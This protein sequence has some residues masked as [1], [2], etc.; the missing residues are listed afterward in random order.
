MRALPTKT[1]QGRS[2]LRE[3]KN[4]SRTSCVPARPRGKTVTCDHSCG[5]VVFCGQIGIVDREIRH[6][7]AC[8]CRE[9]LSGQLPGQLYFH[10]YCA[11]FSVKGSPPLFDWGRAHQIRFQAYPRKSRNPRCRKASRVFCFVRVQGIPGA[12]AHRGPSR[13]IAVLHQSFQ[14]L[15]LSFDRR[16]ANIPGNDNRPAPS[17]VFQVFQETPRCTPRPAFRPNV[18]RPPRSFALR[19]ATFSSSSTSSCSASTPRRS[20]MSSFPRKA[21]SHR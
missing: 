11:A 10:E 18:P 19:P 8:K 5:L 13:L 1:P 16:R 17:R 20:P 14:K 21:N 7:T 12:S 9:F 6:R 4:G 2:T 3:D 15:H